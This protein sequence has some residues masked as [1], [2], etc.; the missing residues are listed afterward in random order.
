MSEPIKSN[1]EPNPVVAALEKPLNAL[2]DEFLVLLGPNGVSTLKV[3]FISDY[4]ERTTKVQ[5]E[6][7]VYGGLIKWYVEYYDGYFNIFGGDEIDK[8]RDFLTR[9]NDYISIPFDRLPLILPMS[10]STLQ[11]NLFNN[12][13]GHRLRLG[14]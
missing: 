6:I 5:L 14:V 11:Y 2:L 13:I 7:G 10:R 1:S 4:K 12:L 9:F 3:V 8:F